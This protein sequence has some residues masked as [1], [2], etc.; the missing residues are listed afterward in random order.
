MVIC[1]VNMCKE[2][3]IIVKFDR[4][5]FM[6]CISKL[7]AGVASSEEMSVCLTRSTHQTW[8]F[9]FK[10]IEFEEEKKHFSLPLIFGEYPQ[11]FPPQE[12]P[13]NDLRCLRTSDQKT[14]LKKLSFRSFL[15]CKSQ[16]QLD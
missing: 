2:V 8:G 7:G 3:K 14:K 5:V 10:V 12:C 1:K 16:A 6:S 13:P 11:Y 4:K 9:F 15:C